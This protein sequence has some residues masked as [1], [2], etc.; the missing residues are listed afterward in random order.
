M[1][2]GT[3][4]LQANMVVPIDVNKEDPTQVTGMMTMEG[5]I[6]RMIK[7]M[8]PKTVRVSDDEVVEADRI[9]AI[10]TKVARS[11]YIVLMKRMIRMPRKMS[12]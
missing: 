4:R 6:M 10:F 1:H 8:T 12:A 3:S 11:M 5:S 7:V 2:G 9:H